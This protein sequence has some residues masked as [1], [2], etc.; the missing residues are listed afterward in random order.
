MNELI[1]NASTRLYLKLKE[2]EL[3]SLNISEYNKNYVNKYLNN[4]L[5]YIPLYTQLLQ[6]SISK[7]NKPISESTF[8]DYG[9]GCGILSFLAIELGF[10]NVIYSDLYSVSVSDTKILSSKL[11][12]T[13]NEFI[14]GD[15]EEFIDKLFKNNIKPDLICSFDVLEHIYDLENWFNKLSQIKNNFHL[16]FMTS[17]N[18]HNPFVRNRLKKLQLKAEH[19]GSITSFGWKKSDTRTAYIEVRKEII[20]KTYPNLNSFDVE[21]LSKKTRGLRKDHI[22]KVVLEFLKSSEIN[23]QI[24]HPTNTCDPN[25]GNWTENLIDLNFLTNILIE[26]KYNIKYTNSFYSYS[27]NKVLNLPKY[28]LNFLIKKLGPE[29]LFFSPTYTL[30]LEKNYNKD[31]T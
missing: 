2:L 11:D 20:K 7:L 10:K 22:H 14:C 3:S 9:G 25:N 29:N 5:F 26:K 19:Q 17:A 21:L 13:I 28:I 30:E 27:K 6:K 18:S 16:I 4:Y 24:N 23:Y 1:Y 31:L 15:I 12:L 8:I